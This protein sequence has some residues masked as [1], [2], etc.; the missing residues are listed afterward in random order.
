[1]QTGNL[2]KHITQDMWG[3]VIDIIDFSSTEELDNDWVQV[4]WVETQQVD[5]IWDDLLKVIA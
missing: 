5:F 3:I 1:M 4:L 2:V